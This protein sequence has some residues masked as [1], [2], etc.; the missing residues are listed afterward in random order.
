MSHIDELMALR[1]KVSELVHALAQERRAHDETKK[2]LETA[3][4]M[5]TSVRAQLV[6]LRA[7]MDHAAALTPPMGNRPVETDAVTRKNRDH[8]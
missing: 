6:A 5:L 4:H 8:G 7:S 1:P 3:Q 2:L